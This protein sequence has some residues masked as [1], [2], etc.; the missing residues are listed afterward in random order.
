MDEE[1]QQQHNVVGNTTENGQYSLSI[2]F[3]MWI[4]FFVDLQ[5]QIQQLEVE[6]K[7]IR[8]EFDSQRAKM[9]ELFLQKEGKYKK[10]N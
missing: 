6:K 5:V 2:V 4:S 9:K 1:H 8:E 7:K 3:R 10:Q